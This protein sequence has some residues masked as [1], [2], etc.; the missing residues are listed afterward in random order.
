MMIPRQPMPNP[1]EI[2]GVVD[3]AR[4]L[5]GAE[6]GLA[7]TPPSRALSFPP[8]PRVALSHFVEVRVDEVSGPA[9]EEDGGESEQEEE[10]VAAAAALIGE[11]RPEEDGRQRGGEGPRSQRRVQVAKR[12]HGGSATT[13]SRAQ[14]TGG[15]RPGETRNE[16]SSWKSVEVK[17]YSSSPAHSFLS[18]RVSVYDT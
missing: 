1:V 3:Q 8:L 11:H 6:T 4:L 17:Y 10:G 12:R 13:W 2:S 16:G 15:I 7:S 5:R 9:D 18:S 14:P